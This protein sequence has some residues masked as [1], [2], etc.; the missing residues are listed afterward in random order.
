MA[1]LTFANSLVM[2]IIFIDLNENIDGDV[3]I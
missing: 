1:A 3:V 2:T